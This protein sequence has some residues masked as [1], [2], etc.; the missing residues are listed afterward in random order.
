ML[1]NRLL[2]YSINEGCS[3]IDD[4]IIY[5]LE[6]LCTYCNE[7]IITY[8]GTLEETNRELLKKYSEN[9]IEIEQNNGYVKGYITAL[10]YYGL[11]NLKN[12]DNILLVNSNIAGPINSFDE[13]FF[14]M[15]RENADF[16]GI[17]ANCRKDII[18]NIPQITEYVDTDFVNIAQSMFNTEMFRKFIVDLNSN[19]DILNDNDKFRYY[20]TQYFKEAGFKYSVFLNNKEIKEY[21]PNPLVYAPVKV[22]MDYGCPVISLDVFKTEYRRYLDYTN[23]ES[24]YELVKYI[25][26]KTLYNMDMITEHILKTNNLYDVKTIMQ[27]NY[28]L[29]STYTNDNL[30]NSAKP[31]TAL[32]LHMY[33]EDLFEET[34]NYAKNMPDYADIYISTQTEDKK[35]KIE[36]LVKD[37]KNKVKVMVI[38]NRGRDVSA[39]TVA[40]REYI[41]KYDI[42]CFAHDKKVSHLDYGIKGAGYEYI[43]YENTLLSKAYIE[44][45]INIFIED[46]KI[47][48]LAPP[49]PQFANFYLVLSADNNGWGS[50][51]EIC[52][53][54]AKKLNLQVDIDINKA[55]VA[56]FGSIFW[57]RVD[58]LK[59][60]FDLQLDYDDFPEEP[61]GVD[62]TI[63][64]AIERI[65]PFISQSRGYYSGHIYSDKFVKMHLTNL[66]YMLT[67]V[68]K[69]VFTLTS[70]DLFNNSLHNLSEFKNIYDNT[71]K[72]YNEVSHKLIAMQ[73]EV[74]EV[75]HLR[76]EVERLNSELGSVYNSKSW[77][78]T[79]PLRT[80]KQKIKNLSYKIKNIRNK[81]VTTGK[82]INAGTAGEIHL[83]EKSKYVDSNVY[84]IIN[85]SE[86]FDKDWYKKEYGLGESIDPVL[87]YI[88]EG[89]DLG[90]KTS[91][92][93]DT[94]K[95]V[96]INHDIK[97]LIN[98]LYHWLTHGIAEHRVD[99]TV[100]VQEIYP[101]G[102][103]DKP[104]AKNILLVTHMLNH[105]GAPVVLLQ[106]AVNLKKNNYNVYVLSPVDDELKDDFIKNDIP[107]WINPCIN[108]KNQDIK[109]NKKFDFCLVNT[110]ECFYAYKKI[111]KVVPAILW[112]HENL[113]DDY[114][115][116]HDN[117]KQDLFNAGSDIY[118]VSELTRYY[119]KFYN[120]ATQLLRYNMKDEVKNCNFKLHDPLRIS[121]IGTLCYRKGQDIFI[122]AVNMLEEDI[123]SKCEFIIVGD[124]SAEEKFAAQ[125]LEKIKNNRHII[126]KN[127][128]RDRK[129]YL[130]FIDGL[131]IL[132]CTSRTDPFP[133]VISECMMYGKAC[134]ISSNVGQSRIY[135]HDK[136]LIVFESEN[137]FD[138]KNKLE[139]LILNQEKVVQLQMRSREIFCDEFGNDKQFKNLLKIIEEKSKNEQL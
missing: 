62:G 55:P 42:V 70:P 127:V 139:L 50:N 52:C 72:N 76:S 107:V 34:L 101:D 63:S 64:H 99:I 25:R 31:K 73:E 65:H 135:N 60:L 80:V 74:N 113:N 97:G 110:I 18:D 67:A 46:K 29:P 90:Y 20:F 102:Y 132:C 68:N 133:L 83:T 95:Y 79:K 92:K 138:L 45:V 16:W 12:F 77:T 49:V 111:S 41:Y 125:V 118:A 126:F 38:K 28:V 57:F 26:E 104:D 121:I 116:G 44:N 54:L 8:T 36:N 134:L 82:T 11:N 58:A 129:E 6:H 1:I 30:K 71:C 37:F 22:I 131:D 100:G 117:L 119:L 96:E 66:Q 33:F 56:P 84:N 98:P 114:F 2:I 130:N 53:D 17:V 112:V 108:V 124:T 19:S 10:L 39:L 136:D 120:P 51:Y 13:L 61:L 94:A 81:P 35:T 9:I 85:N 32:M 69:K 109:L 128:I 75:F 106:T 59:P 91:E 24:G 47:G 89:A 23:G 93:F 86:L 3:N 5:M 115:A 123:K 40:F 48:I 15:D 14:V 122:N 105:T 88:T 103:M 21:V 87:H 137:V 4:Y 7:V 43:C 27:L 78:I